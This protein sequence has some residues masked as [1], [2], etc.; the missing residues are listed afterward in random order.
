MSFDLT[1]QTISSTYDRV[2]QYVSGALYN[3]TG[4]QIILSVPTTGSN[5]FV[6]DQTISGSVIITGS[7]VYGDSTQYSLLYTQD[8]IITTLPSPVTSS[9]D[10]F[11]VFV[12]ESNSWMMTNIVDG[13]IF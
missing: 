8:S 4:N 12:S 2:V 9:G 6:G 13:G 5:V 3:G 1:G 11:A 7:I 10:T